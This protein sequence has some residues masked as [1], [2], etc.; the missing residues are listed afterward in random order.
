[1][2]GANGGTGN[3]I[4]GGGGGGGGNGLGVAAAG[5][6]GGDAS[7][8]GNGGTGGG[9]GGGSYALQSGGA[10]G[11]FGGGGGNGGQG[12]YGGGSGGVFAGGQN[13]SGGFG[14]GGGGGSIGGTGGGSGAAGNGGGGGAAFG[15]AVFVRGDTGAQLVIA[16]GS[17]SGS[18]VTAG[19]GNGTGTNGAAAG[20][21]LFLQSG[22]ITT[23]APAASKTITINTAIADD[24]AASVASGHGYT[25]G[26]G[27][28]AAIAIG[29]GGSAGGTVVFNAA[30]TYTGATT[31]NAG[32]LV[33]NGSIATSS[34][35]AVNNTGTLSGVG[36][37][38][39]TQVNAGGTFA[40]GSGAPGSS[41]TVTGNLT[42]AAA[43]QY[44]VQINPATASFAA[45]S[46]DATLGGATVNATF[47][48]GS[49]ISK[50]YTILT[51][52]SRAGMFG[53]LVNTNLPSNFHDTLSYDATH[54]YLNLTLDFMPPAGPGFGSGLNVNQQ[55]VANALTN[56]FNT[57]GGIPA[58]FGSLTPAG[59]TQASGETATG[60]QQTTFDAMKHVHGRADRSLHRRPRRWRW[61]RRR[62]RP[63]MPT[64]QRRQPA[65]RAMPSAMF[66]KAPP[67]PTFD[68]AL[69]RMGG[70]LWRLADHQRQCGAGIERHRPA[71][72]TARPSAPTIASRRTRWP[73]SRSP[74]AAPISVSPMAAPAVPTCS[75]PARS[76]GIM[77]VRPTSPA[78]SPMAG[79]TSPPTA[80]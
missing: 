25:A 33:V 19:S 32:T 39:T 57:T 40:P 72:S 55:N 6:G 79:R 16:D 54:A 48:S 8:G 73:A 26:T 41:M 12:G 43:A 1:M 53:T 59:L 36:T 67:A 51:A 23:F 3:P 13:G 45:V 21:D 56:F 35:T 70:G 50:R 5:T 62:R 80:P 31:I 28:G 24:S 77:S 65:D 34:L 38:G 71:A 52:G 47:A 42:L 20:Q 75:R 15:G 58:V 4:I 74:A 44:M 17:F 61:A 14:G 27:A 29:V 46:G 7:S 60:S 11:D 2:G 49:Y 10:G 30:N 64:S 18:G 22:S 37:V 78:R 63:A 69:E 76:C 9:G 66:T 68:A